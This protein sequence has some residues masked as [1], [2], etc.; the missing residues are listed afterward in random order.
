MPQETET[1]LKNNKQKTKVLQSETLFKIKTVIY[2]HPFGEWL[3]SWREEGKQNNEEINTR[4][5]C[6]ISKVSLIILWFALKV[7]HHMPGLRP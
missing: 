2:K 1:I 4:A 6:F 5:C 7:I 3:I